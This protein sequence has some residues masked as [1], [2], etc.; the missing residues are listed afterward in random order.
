MDSHPVLPKVQSR[1]RQVAFDDGEFFR[2]KLG[3]VVLSNEQT[4]ENDC[5]RLAPE[6]VG[7]HF[8]RQAEPTDSTDVAFLMALANGLDTAS[9]LLLPGGKLDMCTYTCSCATAVL[10]ENLIRK[11]LSHGR[12]GVQV[13]TV[14]SGTVAALRAVGAS[15]IVVGTAYVDSVNAFV[16]DYLRK[17]GFD[18]LDIQGLQLRT[19]DEIIRATPSF[20]RDF[21]I[22]L[23]RPDAEAI[24][25]S[26]GAMRT[27]D[28][29]DV[30]EKELGKPLIVS[31][32]AM[33]WDSL[34]R[35]GVMDRI[36]GYGGLLSL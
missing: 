12:P 9:A 35:T 25:I 28:I 7:V 23:N 14:M 36:E 11:E 32:Q 15:R 5:L 8:S 2:A 6:G 29:V 26:C 30:V 18:V 24:F 31:N 13:S 27:L 34:R 16:L 20:L 3:F 4:V 17:E 22:S 21:A 1:P 19:D 33:M 10:G